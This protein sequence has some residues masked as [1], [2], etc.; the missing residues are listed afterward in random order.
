MLYPKRSIIPSLILSFIEFSTSHVFLHAGAQILRNK[1][2]QLSPRVILRNGIEKLIE[3]ILCLGILLVY[4]TIGIVNVLGGL[5]R[6]LKFI[7]FKL[8]FFGA[9][10]LG[11]FFFRDE[12]G[13]LF[14][15]N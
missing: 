14:V 11:I 6:D 15:H 7:N 1:W 5:S 2:L 3:L 4:S 9:L 8:S 12:L 10:N 13:V